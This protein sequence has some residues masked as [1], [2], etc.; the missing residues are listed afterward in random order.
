ML[1]GLC[2]LRLHTATF[3]YTHRLTVFLCYSL[4]L[5]VWSLT[6]LTSDRLTAGESDLGTHNLDVG[7][8]FHLKECA[9]IGHHNETSAGYGIRVKRDV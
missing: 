1:N 6:M 8:H 3:K 9:E 2:S 4:C 5:W 7:A